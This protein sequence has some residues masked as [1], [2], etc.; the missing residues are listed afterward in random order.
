[1]SQLPL[2][3]GM[4]AGQ[5]REN[6]NDNLSQLFA[7]GGNPV[8][9]FDFTQVSPQDTWTVNHDLGVYPSVVIRDASGVVVNADIR[10]TSTLQLIITF[11]SPFA[12]SCRCI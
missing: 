5:F 7:G 12:G 8:P 1:M 11:A 6:L 9:V 10:Y 3:D 4:P 2:D